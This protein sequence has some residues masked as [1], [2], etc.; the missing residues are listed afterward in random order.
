MAYMGGTRDQ[1]R[2]VDR[3]DSADGEIG[4]A[5][6]VHNANTKKRSKTSNKDKD[7]RLKHYKD[8]IGEF[9]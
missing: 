7:E 3:N 6:T 5:G 2:R 8:I 1:Q 4:I 9:D